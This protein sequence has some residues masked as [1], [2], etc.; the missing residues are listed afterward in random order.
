MAKVIEDGLV[1]RV[2]AL[3]TLRRELRVTESP[4]VA[5]IIGVRGVGKS[6]L[7]DVIRKD[8]E[9][10]GRQVVTIWCEQIANISALRSALGDLGAIGN[11]R[12]ALLY[13]DAFEHLAPLSD[14]FF[15]DILPHIGG[16]TL[17]VLTS[18]TRLSA[19]QRALVA[20]LHTEVRLSPLSDEDSSALLERFDVA[21]THREGIVKA[22]RGLPLALVLAG[23]RHRQS[24]EAIGV[25]ET[26]DFVAELVRD[27]I[28]DTPSLDHR[29]AL[30]TSAIVPLSPARLLS[31]VKAE[32][33]ESIYDWVRAQPYI[34][35]TRDGLTPHAWV[36]E[37][38]YSDLA[39][40]RPE[41]LRELASAAAEAL[42]D[43]MDIGDID[44][45]R[46]AYIE[47]LRT[48]RDIPLIAETFALE[49]VHRTSLHAATEAHW[50]LLRD[51]VERHE[52]PD[53]RASLDAVILAQPD[54]L[55]VTYD[56][57]DAPL[58]FIA[59]ITLS[60]EP[61]LTSFDPV[62]DALYAISDARP[63]WRDEGVS[64][65][66]WFMGLDDHQELGLGLS[67][68]M[69]SGPVITA[70][71]GSPVKR[72]VLF[73]MERPERF[74]LL[75]PMMHITRIDTPDVFLGD[76]RIG[77]YLL[78][79]ARYSEG[80]RDSA[81]L[82]L[83]V[84]RGTIRHFTGMLPM[85]PAL[86]RD[87]FGAAVQDALSSFHRSAVL[88][89]N[90][91]LESH[92]VGVENRCEDLRTCLRT[93]VSELALIPGY[94]EL[95]AAIEHT[96]LRPAV[97]QRAAAAELGVPF[98]TYRHRLRKAVEILSEELWTREQ[99]RR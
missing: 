40:R 69:L 82:P 99:S 14:V 95:M 79:L 97:K 66:R 46:R 62:T 17:L 72:R 39:R 71:L 68:S 56:G 2:D 74:L 80:W 12:P 27:L 92:L 98:G 76:K 75:A 19:E 32:E 87:A 60:E 86:E 26:E 1:G 57:T 37:T 7:G 94:D 30:Y 43:E 78:D 21:E 38:L 6:A 34:E 8:A 11:E 35:N 28:G 15:R 55:F 48:R 5:S 65:F 89:Q 77:F 70:L 58:A 88:A 23:E 4:R 3:E 29:R 22:T 45:M 64:A 24:E 10:L 63:E 54:K 49:D 53:A 47:A 42:I 73:A 18:R 93:V 81:Q 61:R 33:S 50:D 96:H 90:P 52:G 84:H 9:Q 16:R 67:S 85:R 41:L 13:L 25:T 83:L 44:S 91:L 59:D 51:S 31:I 20:T 36:R